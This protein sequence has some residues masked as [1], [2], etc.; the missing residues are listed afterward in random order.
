MFFPLLSTIY[1][2]TLP[3]QSCTQL[4]NGSYTKDLSII[5]QDLSRVCLVDNSPIS[6]NV[7][8][9]LFPPTSPTTP[10]TTLSQPTESPSKAGLMIPPIK[11]Y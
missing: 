9:G 8:Q 2:L 6:Y 7:N 10:L 4:P 5:E 11:L 1:C 3:A